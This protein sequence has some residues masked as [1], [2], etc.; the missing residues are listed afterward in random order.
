MRARLQAIIVAVA[1]S[2][3]AFALVLALA[4]GS[5]VGL[6]RIAA[7]FPPLAGGALPFDLQNGLA[8]AD[9]Y[10]QLAAWSPAARTRYYAFSAVDW[11]FPLAAG[12]F[13]AA[14]V[15]VCLR[16]SLPRA[17]A[18]VTGRQLLPLLLLA[19][20]CDWLENVFALLAVGLYP[21]E[22]PL[23]AL[24]LVAAKR[25]KLAALFPS[26]GLMVGLLLYTAVLAVVR[27]AAPRPPAPP[28]PPSA[29]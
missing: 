8:V 26:Q 22:S 25:A 21:L 10:A 3:P 16:R 5:F 7:G 24:G 9:V 15:A 2:G 13:L 19:T 17:W 6:D 23:L 11:L 27:R 29:T 18:W 1:S 14:T 12:L 28:A 20:A 4:V